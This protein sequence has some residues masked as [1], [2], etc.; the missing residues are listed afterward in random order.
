[1]RRDTS[2]DT[3]QSLRPNGVVPGDHLVVLTVDLG[4][5]PYVRAALTS[6]LI[7]SV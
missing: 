3:R 2:Q 7:P 5:D 4:G 1:M 6:G